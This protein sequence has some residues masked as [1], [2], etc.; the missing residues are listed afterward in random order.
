MSRL[1]WWLMAVGCMAA[2]VAAAPP[3]R[4]FEYECSGVDAKCPVVR[5]SGDD[6]AC[7]RLKVRQDGVDRQTG[8]HFIL[9]FHVDADQEPKTMTL[10]LTVG[11]KTSDCP[12]SA[13]QVY[14]NANNDDPRSIDGVLCGI[15]ATWER[16]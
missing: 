1:A 8:A 4:A 15:R 3:A 9:G 14:A 12:S 7:L 16:H 10:E 6:T 2:S 11:E 13:R 5:C